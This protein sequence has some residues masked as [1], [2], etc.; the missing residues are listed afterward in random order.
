MKDLVSRRAWPRNVLA[1]AA[2]AASLV[3]LPFAHGQAESGKVSPDSLLLGKVRV[4][5]T[6]EASVRMFASGDSAAGVSYGVKPPP[7]AKVTDVKLGTQTYG[8]VTLVVCDVSLAIE[9]ASA[10]DLEGSLVIQVRDQKAEVPVRV[11]VAEAEPGLTKVLVAETPF[12]RF[13]TGHGSHFEAWLQVVESAGLDPDYVLVERNRPVFLD[14]TL[15]SYDVVLLG[16]MGVYGLTDE[17][18]QKLRRYLDAGGRV[19]LTA[20]H[21]FRETVPQVNKL[22]EHYGLQMDDVEQPSPAQFRL[23]GDEIVADALTKDVAKVAF[24]RPSPVR[25]L[26][27]AMGKLLVA[28]P[29]FPESGYVAV[30]RSA[31][32]E[33]VVLGTSLWW[34]W[35]TPNKSD[36][37][38]NARLLGNLLKRPKKVE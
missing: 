25:V 11:N 8:T 4:G 36:G 23:E 20:N 35:I 18:R 6:V 15:Y 12:E 14:R 37:A 3:S 31:K 19:V 17:D 13:S 21:F 16:G 7:F 28:A 34:D 38:D 26:E 2:L 22:L 5:S 9:T 29:Q 24:F 27:P 10:G 1:L 30:G 32:A 33:I